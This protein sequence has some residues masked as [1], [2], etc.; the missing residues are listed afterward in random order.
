MQRFIAQLLTK[1]F[2]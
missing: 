2:D 1:K